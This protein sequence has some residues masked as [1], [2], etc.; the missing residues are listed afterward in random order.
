MI[1]QDCAENW[2]YSGLREGVKTEW[3]WLSAATVL[4]RG[5]KP[6]PQVSFLVI[7]EDL[8]KSVSQ[9]LNKYG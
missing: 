6:L 9:Q 1:R 8:R 2:G 4:I 7:R 5:W 3:A